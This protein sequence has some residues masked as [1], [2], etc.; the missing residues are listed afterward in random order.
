MLRFFTVLGLSTNNTA[1]YA[2]LG[3]D[4][5]IPIAPR[6]PPGLLFHSER[7]ARQ[8]L[9]GSKRS[10]PPLLLSKNSGK[11]EKTS[12][13][14]SIKCRAG[15]RIER[16]TSRVRP[17]PAIQARPCSRLSSG[18]RRA[19]GRSRGRLLRRS[20]APRGVVEGRRGR[21][22]SFGAFRAAE[23]QQCRR[24]VILGLNLAL[25]WE[26]GARGSLGPLSRQK[27]TFVS[28]AGVAL[29]VRALT[30]SAGIGPSRPHDCAD[31]GSVATVSVA[32][33]GDSPQTGLARQP[34][35]RATETTAAVDVTPT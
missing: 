5:R 17:G 16:R 33:G 32:N 20:G 12:L 14:R 25:T 7:D 21:T 10:T 18:L 34:S 29:F 27:N 4:V 3:M 15:E 6:I 35:G 11:D 9:W 31:L 19:V 8:P 24:C 1:R 23:P 13:R 22:R 30:R 28:F 26:D 2:E